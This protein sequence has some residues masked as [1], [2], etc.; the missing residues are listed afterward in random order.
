MKTYRFPPVLPHGAIQEIFPDVF[1]VT[2]TAQM[3][4]PVPLRFSRNMTI[5]RQGHE[6]TLVNSVRLNEA[7]LKA[8]E[9]LGEVKHVIRLAAFHGMDD[10]FY[11]DRY[12]AEVWSVES[13]YATGTSTK[14]SPN[15]IYFTPNHWLPAESALPL[16]DAE[17]IVLQSPQPQEALL[18]LHRHDGVLISG[19]CL[20][21][22]HTTDQY[23]NLIGKILMK[24]MGFL[25][26]YNVGPA[27]LKVTRPD[28]QELKNLMNLNFTHLL[29]AHG[30]AVLGEAKELYREVLQ[31]L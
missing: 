15:K 1:M 8:L 5:L 20:Q 28:V 13:P 21:N 3:N 22:W 29:P 12:G 30:A 11:Q 14:P 6:L 19:D 7:G 9:T 24:T 17:L 18:L 25:K 10:P 2:G 27:W 16:M 23:F 26:P 4:T 31:Q